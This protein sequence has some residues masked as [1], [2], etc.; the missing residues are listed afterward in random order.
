MTSQPLKRARKSARTLALL[1][2]LV[3]LAA[4]SPA[5]AQSRTSSGG[6]LDPVLQLVCDLTGLLC[7]P[8]PP[9]ARPAPGAPA[10]P[11]EA[12]AVPSDPLQPPSF[13]VPNEAALRPTG[14]GPGPVAP[15]VPLAP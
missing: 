6:L 13:S 12:P 14:G 1:M 8:A 11:P 10:P 7:P 2:F 15:P 4:P 5:W 9:P 3:A